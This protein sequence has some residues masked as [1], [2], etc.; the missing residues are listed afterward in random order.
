MDEPQQLQQLL[1][2]DRSSL[3]QYYREMSAEQGAGVLVVNY[4]PSS[5]IAG[6]NAKKWGQEG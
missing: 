3:S 6:C 4:Y 2:D 1:N 5:E